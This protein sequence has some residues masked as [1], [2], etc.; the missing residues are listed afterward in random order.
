MRSKNQKGKGDVEMKQIDA[1]DVESLDEESGLLTEK[2][3]TATPGVTR[4]A[5]QLSFFT[6][7]FEN[8]GFKLAFCFIGLQTSYILWGLS[9]ERLMTKEVRK[10]YLIFINPFRTRLT[11]LFIHSFI[12]SSLYLLLYNNSIPS[13]DSNQVPLLYS[14]IAF[15]LCSSRWL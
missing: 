13:D 2:N 9:Q 8:R 15:S 14:A 11:N 6:E 10:N 4:A 1:L 5:S 12:N 3:S 7:C